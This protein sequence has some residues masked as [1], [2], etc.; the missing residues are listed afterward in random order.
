MAKKKKSFYSSLR[1]LTKVPLRDLKPIK[2][3]QNR[4]TIHMSLRQRIISVTILCVVLMIVTV[5]LGRNW[6]PLNT[7]FNATISP[8]Q[9]AFS[10]VGEWFSSLSEDAKTKAELQDENDALRQQL[11]TLQYE[12]TLQEV[13]L[14]KM[15][16]LVEL[17]E[18]DQYYAEYPKSAAQV[19]AISSS[20]WYDTITIDKGAADGISD[21]MPV[22]SGGGLL[23]RVETVY[24]HYSRVTSILSEGSYVYAEVLRSGDHVGVQGDI[25]L[26]R[27][28]LC[29]IEFYI[30]QIDIAVGDEIITSSLSDVYPPGIRVGQIIGIEEN[31]DGV[32]GTAYLE[33]YADI[34]DISYVLIMTDL[35]KKPEM[36]EEPITNQDSSVPDMGPDLTGVTPPADS[37]EESSN[38]SSVQDS[39]AQEE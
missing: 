7:V 20:N 29:K 4:R 11:E 8:V 21:F 26:E 1:D 3:E 39:S 17:Y 18:L 38:N 22:L 13:K 15:D 2:I 30:Q 35:E 37:Q 24:Q 5:S 27:D 12:N 16:E 32:T 19:T 34:E 33:P 25:T 14:S 6:G 31:G 28:G 36:T 10:A 9:Q 23:G